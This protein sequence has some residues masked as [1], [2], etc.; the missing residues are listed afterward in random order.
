MGIVFVK[1][2]EFID[3]LVIMHDHSPAKLIAIAAA[4]VFSFIGIAV[5]LSGVGIVEGI[6]ISLF[7]TT[8]V[9]GGTLLSYIWEAIED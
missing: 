5:M 9:F 4:N 1:L 8:F 3:L 2:E 7:L 6:L